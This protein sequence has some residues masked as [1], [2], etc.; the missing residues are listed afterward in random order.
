MVNGAAPR[1]FGVALATHRAEPDDRLLGAGLREREASSLYGD[2]A[3]SVERSPLTRSPVMP[4]PTMTFWHN[5]LI[6]DCPL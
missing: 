5:C 6:G 4:I 1:L 2:R 3:T